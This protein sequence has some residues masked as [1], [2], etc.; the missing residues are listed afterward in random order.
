MSDSTLY[1]AT[2]NGWWIDIGHNYGIQCQYQIG[3]PPQLCSGNRHHLFLTHST[4]N[5]FYMIAHGDQSLR[6]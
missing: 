1:L 6:Y 5:L 2:L 3:D 4:F